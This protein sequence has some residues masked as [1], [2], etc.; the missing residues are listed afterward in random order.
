MYGIV[1]VNIHTI[2]KHRN[3]F[4]LD[5]L[6]QNLLIAGAHNTKIIYDVTNH[7]LLFDNGTILL[8]TSLI[9]PKLNIKATSDSI[10]E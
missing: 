1:Y 9:D 3:L 4:S 2:I 8:T 7:Q 10:A 5:R 6:K